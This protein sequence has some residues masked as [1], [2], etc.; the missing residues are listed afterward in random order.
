ML[1]FV[2]AGLALGWY[3]RSCLIELHSACY[4]MLGRLQAEGDDSMREAAIEEAKEVCRRTAYPVFDVNVSG[5][6][7]MSRVRSRGSMSDYVEALREGG[8]DVE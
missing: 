5:D 6:F 1:V 8:D 4:I 2:V 3:W 7:R